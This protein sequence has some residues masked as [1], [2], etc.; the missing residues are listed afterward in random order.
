[1]K[2]EAW[3]LLCVR[4]WIMIHTELLPKETVQREDAASNM[5]MPAA[6]TENFSSRLIL[7]I[8]RAL[9]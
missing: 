9:F 3:T 8:S 4:Q 1:M 2:T 6:A 5:E 7:S